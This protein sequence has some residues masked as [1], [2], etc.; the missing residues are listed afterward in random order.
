MSTTRRIYF[1]A[2]T[3][4]TLGIFAAGIRNL[5]AL[6]FDITI[7]GSPVVGPDFAR[8]QLSLSLAMIIIGGPLWFWFWK[9]VQRYAASNDMET[10][11]ASRKLFLNLVL[12]ATALVI[13][14][15]GRDFL[16]WLLAGLPQ[17]Q[18]SSGGLA[19]LTVAALV[20]FYHGRISE[21]EGHPSSAAR[22]LRRWYVYVLS[23]WS[24]VWL[25]TAVVQ[26]V[27]IS[28]RSLPIWGDVIVA[29]EFWTNSLRNNIAT[30]AMGTGFWVFHWLRMAEGDLDSTLRQ[31]YLYLLAILNSAIAGLVAFTTILYWLFNRAFGGASNVQFLTWTIPMILLTTAIWSYH[32]RL[33]VEEA[34]EFDERRFSAQR[35]HLYLMSL[36]GLGTMIAGLIALMGILLDFL[37]NAV[38]TG[39]V[40]VAPG[41]WRSQLS[42]SL[43]LLLVGTPLWLNYWNRI[44]RRVAE[45]TAIEWAARSRRVYLYLVVAAAII[46]LAADL[47]NIVYQALNGLLQTTSVADV[48]KKSKWSLQ[49]LL[50]A[51]PVLLYHLRTVRQDL[52]RGAEAVAVHKSVTLLVTDGARD[53][54]TQIEGKLGFRVQVLTALQQEEMPMLSDEELTS[55][56]DNIRAAPGTKVMLVVTGGKIIVTPYESK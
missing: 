19:T 27:N 2:V 33:A 43:S 29:G 46:T 40:A 51:A 38:S 48:L 36:I 45:G 5:L 8:Q 30:M 44:L 52:R 7:K 26:I 17:A 53:L 23:G 11:A 20:W 10:G 12:T 28:L 3:I 16:S 41:W 14:F 50:I 37:I 24:L 21:A 9:T 4:I 31:V 49:T 34:R 39:P 32:E 47:V 15:T 42:L 22:T 54:I 13:L 25:A 56:A 55:L 18:F 35:V 1:Y 6:L